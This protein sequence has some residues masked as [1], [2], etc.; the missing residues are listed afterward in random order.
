MKTALL[1][2]VCATLPVLAAPEIVLT[3]E[4][5]PA[6]SL[7]EGPALADTGEPRSFLSKNPPGGFMQWDFPGPGYRRLRAW[8]ESRPWESSFNPDTK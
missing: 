4:T 2:V 3:L 1:S 6:I 5:S 7:R 8:I